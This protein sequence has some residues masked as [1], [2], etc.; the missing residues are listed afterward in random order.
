LSAKEIADQLGVPATTLY[1]FL[2]TLVEHRYLGVDEQKR[3]HLGLKLLERVGEIHQVYDVRSVARRE[4]VTLSRTVE[5]NARLAVLYGNDVL[6]LEQ[7]EGGPQAN[8]ILTE[9]VGLRVPSYCT[10]LGKVLLAHL[11]EYDLARALDSMTLTK[12]T[13]RTITDRDRLVDELRAVRD[14]GYA[15]ELEELQLGA[16]CVAA[17]IRNSGSRVIAAISTSVLASRARDGELA[18]IAEVVVATAADISEQLGYRHE[19]EKEKRR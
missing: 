14:R 7:E 18:R 16:A 19:S 12:M 5:A 17:P 2:H 3:Y 8:L 13:D 9:V 4:L 15:L 10:A 1:P 6:Y 11:P